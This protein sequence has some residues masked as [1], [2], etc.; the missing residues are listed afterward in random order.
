MHIGLLWDSVSRN[1]GDQAIGI[2]LQRI[3]QQHGVRYQVI[4][5]FKPNMQDVA[6]LIVGGGEL[7]R[8]PGHHFYDAFRVPGPHIL[9]TVGVL[10]ATDADYLSDYRLVTTRSGADAAKLGRG[11]VSPCLTLLY[12]KYLPSG[13]P[14]I[15]IPDGA[16]GFHITTAFHEHCTS[17]VEWLRKVDIGPVVWLPVTHYNGDYLLMKALAAHVPGSLILPRM[18]PDDT[19]RTIGRM[20]ALVS[21]SL[22]A[23]LFAYTQ[24]IP[25]LATDYPNKINYFLSERDLHHYSFHSTAQIAERLPLLLE[26]PPSLATRDQDRLRCQQT[27]S[28]IVD[29]ALQG[30]QEAE[31]RTLYRLP[32]T[33]RGA[34]QGEMEFYQHIAEL[35][36]AFLNRELRMKADQGLAIDALRARYPWRLVETWGRVKNSLKTVPLARR[37]RT[38]LQRVLRRGL[39]SVARDPAYT[40]YITTVEDAGHDLRPDVEQRSSTEDTVEFII[41]TSLQSVKL[42][43]LKCAFQ[44]VQAQVFRNWSWYLIDYGSDAAVSSYAKW[45]SL[46]DSRVQVVKRWSGSDAVGTL[47]QA[48]SATQSSYVVF[49]EPHDRLDARALA[50]L[51]GAV[52]RNRDAD[53]VYSDTDRVDEQGIRFDPLFKPDW[54]PETFLSVDLLQGATAIRTD[55]L[56][57]VLSQN[58]LSLNIDSR[59][60]LLFRVTE[61]ASQIRHVPQILGHLHG[62]SPAD[63]ARDTRDREPV[64]EHLRRCGVSIDGISERKETW[65]DRSLRV[66]WLPQ[67]GHQV[68]IIIPSRDKPAMLRYSLATLLERTQYR[69]FEIIVVDTRSEEAETYELYDQLEA[70]HG[71]RIVHND[72]PFN[73][74]EACNLG[75]QAASGELL[76]FLNNDTLVLHDDWLER[77]VQWFDIPRVGVTGAKLLRPEGTIQHAGVILGMSGLA[78][79]P[80]DGLEEGSK[81][82]FG[83]DT[84]YRNLLAVT[85]ACLVI[86]RSIFEEI[87]GFDEGYRLLY[88]DTALCLSAY[89]AGYRVVYTPDARLLHFESSTHKRLVPHADFVRA[90]EQFKPWLE[91]GDPFFN[92]NMTYLHPIPAFSGH[93]SHRPLDHTRQLLDRLPDK[94]WFR[95]PD[96]LDPL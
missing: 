2:V 23:T 66:T 79:H 92:P 51:A 61:A 54:S 85:A 11:E 56:L 65:D 18:T 44:S 55:L 39:S 17:L 48:M 71:V 35:S 73:F 75:A 59:S 12:D 76:L 67:H 5:P 41:I 77:L 32:A 47:S 42:P 31:A 57:E 53:I 64:Q 1:V 40:E 82:I 10:D 27:A 86:R 96:D 36:T 91:K 6:T 88:S 24:N 72:R 94:D 37:I 15:D 50:A 14:P 70:E 8:A 30:L 9:N 22:H 21:S 83:S 80:F 84:W 58:S 7:I 45:K 29:Q 46:L 28:Q 16:I 60:E 20:R 93:S 95:I 34:Y 19:F 3:L 81:T 52:Y 68:S 33:H 74:S 38:S 4:D 63:Y 43:L 87:G 25:F 78:A 69:N 89:R 26:S 13:N 49:L 90:A 62:N